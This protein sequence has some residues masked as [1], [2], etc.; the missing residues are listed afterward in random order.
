MDYITE[1]IDIWSHGNA[2]FIDL[3]RVFEVLDYK[4]LLQNLEIYEVNSPISN[5]IR[6]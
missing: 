5:W 4:I 2:C 3:K 6:K 1:N